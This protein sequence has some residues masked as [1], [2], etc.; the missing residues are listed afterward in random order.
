[1]SGLIYLFFNH[2]FLQIS[3]YPVAHEDGIFKDYSALVVNNSTFICP[4]A[5]DSGEPI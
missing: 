2:P 4:I 1:M 3:Y 5:V